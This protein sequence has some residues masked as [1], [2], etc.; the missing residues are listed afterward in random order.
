M[1]EIKTRMSWIEAAVGASANCLSP[2]ATYEFSYLQLRLVCE[3]L[4]L[5]CLAVHGEG[6]LREK[7]KSEYAADKIINM[8]E[9]LHPDFYPHR[10]IVSL[11]ESGR[12][13]VEINNI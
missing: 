6:G 3:T 9:K 10:S 13:D 2:Q 5:G 12:Y 1:E 11:R 4:A 7:L 8:V